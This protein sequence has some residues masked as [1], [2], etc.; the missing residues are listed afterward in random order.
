[1]RIDPVHEQGTHHWIIT[2]DG[3][4]SRSGTC[5]PKL[6]ETR[7]DLYLR[8]RAEV[9]DAAGL[10]DGLAPVTLAFDVQPNLLTGV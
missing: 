10:A 4:G 2:L 6:G 5:T 7:Y 1:M 3:V 9:L 8:I